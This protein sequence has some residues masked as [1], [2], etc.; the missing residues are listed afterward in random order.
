MK[1]AILSLSIVIFGWYTLY[2]GYLWLD[3]FMSRDPVPVSTRGYIILAVSTTITL[4]LL[5][6]IRR[7]IKKNESSQYNNTLGDNDSDIRTEVLN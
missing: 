1:E 5:W 4:I 7:I 3:N 2:V 6:R